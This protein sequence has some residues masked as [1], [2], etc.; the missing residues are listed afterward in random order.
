MQLFEKVHRLPGIYRYLNICIYIFIVLILQVSTT[1][2]VH[3]GYTSGTHRVH[4][5][6]RTGTHRMHR[7]HVGT[8][9]NP[10]ASYVAFV[11]VHVH[12][13]SNL[14]STRKVVYFFPVPKFCRRIYEENWKKTQILCRICTN[15]YEI[16]VAVGVH[17]LQYKTPFW[18]KSSFPGF[19]MVSSSP[20]PEKKT[21]PYFQ[22]QL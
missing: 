6:L 10:M 21:R 5:G 18:P 8:G 3:I 7:V 19:R 1:T 4:I 13:N 11:P 14:K 22:Q 12:A 20:S 2:S 9:R 17:M 16:F 15:F